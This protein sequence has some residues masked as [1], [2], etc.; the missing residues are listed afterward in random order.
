MENLYDFLSKHERI[1]NAFTFIKN[2][3]IM[4]KVCS[5][6]VIGMLSVGV[7]IVCTGITLG[8][9][10]NY[11]GSFIATVRSASVFNDAKSIA[12]ENISS[13]HAD[14]AI[15]T[16]S[17]E[18]TITVSEKLD[19]A[20]TLADAIIENTEDIVSGTALIING[21]TVSVANSD[22]LD[23]YMKAR[24]SK[25]DIK[26]ANNSS[27]FTADV[28]TEKSYY[29]KSEL[30]SNEE[31]KKIVDALEVK[32]V[33]IATVDSAIPFTTQTNKTSSHFIGY[34]AV[35]KAG[36]NGT[37]RTTSNI[38]LIN[39]VEVSRTELDSEVIAEPIE[40][41]VLVGTA[42]SMSTPAERSEER[43]HGFICPIKKGNFI[44]SSYWG[45]G[46]NHQALDLAADRGTPIY[47]VSAGKVTF[48]GYSGGYGYYVTI[49]H[50]NGIETR[51]AHASSLCVNAGQTVQQGDVIALVGSTGYSTGNHLH[52]E[53]IVGGVRVNPISY[54]GLY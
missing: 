31:V 8:F 28:K 35:T 48:A 10:V 7:T 21:E 26:N 15:E 1:K 32:T 44:I 49:D 34:R 13:D 39:G 54:I 40:E 4:A 29:L 11:S 27:E 38:E 18:A 12:V 19:N 47:A 2:N 46:R 24:L 51:Y 17:F 53:V 6:C 52:F 22:E 5:L 45:D 33:S 25:Y 3:N 42:I 9:K 30:D 16:P 36:K 20:K 14:S 23:N 50:G 41:V 43:S 37:K